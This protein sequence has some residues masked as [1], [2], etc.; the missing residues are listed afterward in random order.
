MIGYYLKHHSEVETYLRYRQ[1]QADEIRKQNEL[2][3]DPQG[4]R[5]RLLARRSKQK[6]LNDASISRLC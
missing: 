5:D 3:F 2:R 1:Q 4:V 6:V